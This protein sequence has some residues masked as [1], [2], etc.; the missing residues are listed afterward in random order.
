MQSVLTHS[1]AGDVK[2][3]L[4]RHREAAEAAREEID[5]ISQRLN[6]DISLPSSEKREMKKEIERFEN[7]EKAARE[8]VAR[9]TS[10]SDSGSSLAHTAL[11]I[12]KD[13]VLP[14]TACQITEKIRAG[15]MQLSNE[16]CTCKGDNRVQLGHVL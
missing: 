9:I 6:S 14:P 8:T 2:R 10:Q 12:T 4:R 16:K 7:T 15:V 13:L 11:P 5:R 1:V 3:G